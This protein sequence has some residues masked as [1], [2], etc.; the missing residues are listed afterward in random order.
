MK[1]STIEWLR[2]LKFVLFSASAGIVQFGSFTLLN[3][4]T[5]WPY[6]PCYLVSLLL[7]ILW[8]FTFNRRFTFKSNANITK[9]MLLVLAFYVVF[10]PSTTCLGNWLAEDLLWNEYIVTLINMALNLSLEYLYQRYVVYRNKID[11]R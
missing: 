1:Q 4:F 7:S 5:Q 10:T 6:W 3:E 8:N 9:A 2:L 11:N